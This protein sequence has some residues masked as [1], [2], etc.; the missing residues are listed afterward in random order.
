MPK[1]NRQQQ[2][3]KSSPIPEEDISFKIPRT[4]ETQP[5][6]QAIP[7][8]HLPKKNKDTF[9]SMFI[10]RGE[11]NMGSKAI[12]MT[13]EWSE[14]KQEEVRKIISLSP[15]TYANL[16]IEGGRVNPFNAGASTDDLVTK[17]YL[18][19]ED[20]YKQGLLEEWR[21][22]DNSEMERITVDALGKL[23][24]VYSQDQME[25]KMREET[26]A[27]KL[28]SFTPEQLELLAQMKRVQNQEPQGKVVES[29][30]F[31]LLS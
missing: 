5:T 19:Q 16:T 27:E 28:S 1:N 29:V 30:N 20:D 9:V 22:N 31:N 4:P 26:F 3:V 12:Y 23:E 8:S 25:R 11:T 2:P 18:R 13:Y 21:I 14:S 15:K 7:A 17:R 24:V 6:T 10:Y